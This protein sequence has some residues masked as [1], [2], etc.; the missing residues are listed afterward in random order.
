MVHSELEIVQSIKKMFCETQRNEWQ[1]KLRL[2]V[3]TSVAVKDVKSAMM[4][5]YSS[6][7]F[8]DPYNFESEWSQ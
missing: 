6:P 4:K 8:N 5:C 3:G 2:Y 7:K 1:N